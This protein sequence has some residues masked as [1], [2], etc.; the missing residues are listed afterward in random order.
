MYQ[1]YWSFCATEPSNILRVLSQIKNAR[2]CE[3]VPTIKHVNTPLLSCQVGRGWDATW[4]KALNKNDLKRSEIRHQAARERDLLANHIQSFRWV[5][6]IVLHNN[7]LFVI[8]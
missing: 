8:T 4:F 2:D 5:V 3:E 6:Y 7:I 1:Y